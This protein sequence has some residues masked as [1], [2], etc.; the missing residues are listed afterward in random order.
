MKREMTIIG[1]SIQY[2]NLGQLN[3]VDCILHIDSVSLRGD[4]ALELIKE[5]LRKDGQFPP[6]NLSTPHT[7]PHPTEGVE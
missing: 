4:I 3:V 7:S 5:Q 6:K 2:G 1:D